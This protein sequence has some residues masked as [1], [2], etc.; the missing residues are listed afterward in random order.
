[1]KPIPT[2]DE[3]RERHILAM[4]AKSQGVCFRVENN[5]KALRSLEAK[6]FVTIEKR[7]LDI[8]GRITDAGLASFSPQERGAE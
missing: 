8:I 4:A 5:I 3:A 2:I 6:G 1:M 7:G